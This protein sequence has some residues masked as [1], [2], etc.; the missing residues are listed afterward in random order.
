MVTSPIPSRPRRQQRWRGCHQAHRCRGGAARRA[1]T[2][3]RRAARLGAVFDAVERNE[4]VIAGGL[5]ASLVAAAA[6]FSGAGA[7]IDDVELVKR[8]I[9]AGTTYSAGDILAAGGTFFYLFNAMGII[10]ALYVR[11]P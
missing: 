5:W 9:A 4:R 3:T 10:P 2:V 7:G 8:V 1:S 11:V 6:S